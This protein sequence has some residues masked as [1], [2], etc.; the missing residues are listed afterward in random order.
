MQ[1]L[2]SFFWGFG[3][4]NW[5]ILA[6]LLLILETVV[7]GVHFLWF[8]IAAVIVGAIAMAT[9]IAWQWQIIAFGVISVLTV[10][11]VRRYVRPDVATSDLP[12]LN[13]RGQ[14]YIGRSL[15]VEQA[16]QNGRGKVRVGDTLWQAEGPDAPA[17]ARVKVT[18][19]KGNVL[20][21]ERAAA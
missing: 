8:G 7:P 13:V 19:S 17:G 12:D 11:F 10:F 15:V 9:G 5:L 3:V 16:I 18:A 21:V 2:L 4:W 14:Q 6:V 20:V 1:G